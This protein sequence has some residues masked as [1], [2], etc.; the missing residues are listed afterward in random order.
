MFSETSTDVAHERNNDLDDHQIQRT[1]DLNKIGNF[2]EES[3][4][5]IFQH[6]NILSL[7]N[8]TTV[9]KQFQTLAQNVF[10]K[11]ISSEITSYG[12][13][14]QINI[15]TERMGWKLVVCRFRNCITGINFS[16]D[17]EENANSRHSEDVLRFMDEFMS[18]S[19]LKSVTFMIDPKQFRNFNFRRIFRNLEELIL[20]YVNS[21]SERTVMTTLNRWCPNLKSL[22]ITNGQIRGSHFFLQSLSSL[23]SLKFNNVTLAVSTE[24]ITDFFLANNQLKKLAIENVKT[25]DANMSWLTVVNEQLP[26]LEAMTFA[27]NTLD[28]LPEFRHNFA[29]LKSLSFL[30]ARQRDWTCWGTVTNQ[31]LKIINYLP[32]IESLRVVNCSE[33]LMTNDN[34]IELIGQSSATLKSLDIMGMK[35]EREL[36]FGYDLHRQIYGTAVRSAL[37]MTFQFGDAFV[38]FRNWMEMKES[39]MITFNITKDGIW[40]NGKLI[41][42][43][44]KLLN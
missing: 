7:A 17:W 15:N 31:L 11:M 18:E 40:E 36:K 16:Q 37:C 6:L 13:E 44:S 14:Y 42:V 23:E 32:K 10:K 5:Q 4:T 25:L 38:S 24:C 43:A 22:I 20:F 9:C 21:V 26:N 8:V 33:N 39:V 12:G 41:V 29:N 35:Y 1:W 2:D 28:S 3:W 19:S 34:L 27:T 30:M